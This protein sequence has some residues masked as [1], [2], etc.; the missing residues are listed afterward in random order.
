VTTAGATRRAVTV[1]DEPEVAEVPPTRAEQ[2]VAEQALGGRVEDVPA[3]APKP[4]PA[5]NTDEPQIPE[6]GPDDEIW[7]GG[8]TMAV[9]NQWKD[10]H[11]DGNIYVTAVTP[12]LNVVWRT[13][14]RFEYRRLVKGIEQAVSTGQVSQAEASLNQEEQVCE[15]CMLYPQAT[16]QLLSG[17]LAGLPSLIAQEVMQASGFEALEVRQL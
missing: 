16:R 13:L 11:G 6:L 17:E 14:T 7:D 15:L 2:I 8:P 3:P 1:P 5:A 12:T 10:Q 4:Q 9:I